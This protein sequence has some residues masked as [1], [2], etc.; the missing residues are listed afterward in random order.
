M[1]NGLVQEEGGIAQRMTLKI[2]TDSMT[3]Q[4]SLDKSKK[5]EEVLLLFNIQLRNMYV[6]GLLICYYMNSSVHVK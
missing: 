3:D 2:T 1:N 4:D 5:K 6:L